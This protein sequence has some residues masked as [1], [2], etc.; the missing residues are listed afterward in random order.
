MFT[1]PSDCFSFV[2][3]AL[4]IV[5]ILKPHTTTFYTKKV[6]HK[7]QQHSICLAI[8]DIVFTLGRR[9]RLFRPQE[10]RTRSEPYMEYCESAMT[11]T[12]VAAVQESWIEE[13]PLVSAISW[14]YG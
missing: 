6:E 3:L 4:P 10:R 7:L 2:K 12:A 13:A 1:T 9:H 8:N 11:T 5:E 14:Q